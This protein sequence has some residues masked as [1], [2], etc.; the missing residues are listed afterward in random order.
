ME[1]VHREF[2]RG[3]WA[4]HVG[5]YVR[6]NHNGKNPT[7]VVAMLRLLGEEDSIIQFLTDKHCATVLQWTSHRQ[8]VTTTHILPLPIGH[9]IFHVSKIARKCL[10]CGNVF[11]KISP[12]SFQNHFNP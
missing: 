12:K 8:D 3:G 6:D 7:D 4:A 11:I 10:D 5:D 2:W 1:C 9:A